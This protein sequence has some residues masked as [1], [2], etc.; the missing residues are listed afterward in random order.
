MVKKSSME[1]RN[2]NNGHSDDDIFHTLSKTENFKRAIFIICYEIIPSILP[3]NIC[4][5]LYS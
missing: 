5:S 1:T 4:S 2:I 3:T